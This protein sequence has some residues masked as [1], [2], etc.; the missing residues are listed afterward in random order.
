MLL[1][2]RVANLRSLREELELSFVVPPKSDTANARTIVLSDGKELSV[3]PLLGIFGANASGKSNVLSAL[4]WMRDAVL[5]SYAQWTSYQGIPREAF[6]LDPKAAAETTF[7][8]VDF[9]LE[10]G[11]RRTYGFELGS[12]RVE[13]EWLFA[14]PKG[15]K[16]TWFERDASR[17]QVFDF[18]NRRIQDSAR[19]ART[20]RP[21][22]LMLSQAATD[23]HPQLTD[24]Y[25]WFRGNLW[26]INPEAERSQ[27]ESYTALQ[28]KDESN[29]VRIEELLKVAD[30]GIVGTDVVQGTDGKAPQVRLLHLDGAQGDSATSL[31]WKY[32]S[33][34]TRSWFALIGPLLL[35]LDQGA[36]LLI[37]ELD[38]S[39]HPRFAAEVVRIF[40]TPWVNTRGA[41][42]VFTAHDPSLLRGQGG[43]RLLEPGQAWLTEKDEC[44]ATSMFPLSDL[45]PTAAEDLMMSYLDGA[46]G[47]VPRVTEGKIGRKLLAASADRARSLEAG[48]S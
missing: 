14:Y 38:A 25:E 21:N 13:A 48:K 11:I 6:A 22:A 30:L 5:N 23:N 43:L 1:R 24:I 16:Q 4:T 46:F 10:D 8:E 18:P 44:G 35:A 12:S 37:D 32:E 31:D 28:L 29:R 33:Y 9:V 42:L 39:L 19:L 41:Q 47:G 27:R 40:Q 26:A 36:V 45:E 17:P 3:Y 2:F 20:T 15:R 7:C 34:G